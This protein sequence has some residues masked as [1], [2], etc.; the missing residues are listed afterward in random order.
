MAS[1]KYYSLKA[2]LRIIPQ[3]VITYSIL[4]TI[5]LFFTSCSININA[6]CSFEKRKICMPLRTHQ[7]HV[8][9][10]S[11][12]SL[13]FVISNFH[14]TYLT[15]RVQCAVSLWPLDFQRSADLRYSLRCSQLPLLLLLPNCNMQQCKANR[16][17]LDLVK[18][19]PDPDIDD[20][21]YII[22]CTTY[23]IL[24]VHE[25]KYVLGSS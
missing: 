23:Y 6:C 17:N 21:F 18:K 2:Y 14:V 5:H 10:H 13:L 7:G 12:I 9:F 15:L 19:N 1:N 11:L 16:P 24:E 3:L 20:R 4:T 25:I 22:V 8:K